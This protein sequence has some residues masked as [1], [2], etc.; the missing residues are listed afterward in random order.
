MEK[1]DAPALAGPPPLPENWDQ[2]TGDEKFQYYATGWAT[3]EGKPFASPEIAEQYQKRAR[4]FLDVIALK[5]PDEVP[6]YLL[7]EGYTLENGGIL[8][9]DAFYHM[10]KYIPAAFKMHDDFELDYSI[11]TYAQSGKVLDTLGVKLIRW[12]GSSLPTALPDHTSFQY[13]EDEYMKPEEYDALINNPEGFI[14]RHYLPRICNELG[15]LATLPNAFNMVEAT[16]F[17][18]TLFGLSQGTPARQAIDTLL[19]AADEGAETMVQ[20][21]DT[22]MQITCKYGTPAL[23]GG[24]TFAPYDLIGDTMRCTM[25][26]MKD[27]Y[28]CPD[29]VLAAVEA[30]TPMSIQMGVQMAM[31][32]RIPFILIPLHKG[33]DGFMSPE[34]F[35]KFYWP[36]LK[37][38]MQG[39]IDA[40]CIPVPFVEGSY[41]QRLDIMAEDPLPSGKTL[42]IF[43]RTDMQAAKEKVGRWGCISGNVP[44][45][46]FKQGTPQMLDEYCK[47]LIE[48]CAPGGGFCVAPGAV[49]DQA[50]PENVRVYLN[51]GRKFG[52]Y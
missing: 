16:G 19:R 4:R 41:N 28:R 36:S 42:W 3:T 51:C 14:L 20:F 17:T 34:Q 49:I 48:T 23:L 25:G 24:I 11:L 33:A 40:G 8:P 2:M 10:D 12:P 1:T 22:L 21:L 45:S 6:V 52:K 44:A 32:T 27:L 47:D 9:V 35:K 43:D 38:T 26:V 39:L 18:G 5:E 31:T 46:H 29:K 30:L 50:N 15:G 7:T 37:A 13:V